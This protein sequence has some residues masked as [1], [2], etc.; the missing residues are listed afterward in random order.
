VILRRLHARAGQII[1]LGTVLILTLTA[2]AQAAKTQYVTTEEMH[3]FVVV[4]FLSGAGVVLGGLAVVFSM[5]TRYRDSEMHAAIEANAATVQSNAEQISE[6]IKMM[7]NH[8]V[9]PFAHPIGS[10]TRIDPIN[11][12]LDALTEKLNTLIG[13]HD[14]IQGQEH[15]ICEALAELR[16][17]NPADS[18]YPKRKDDSRDDYTPLR[19][20]KP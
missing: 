5:V 2:A 13:Q 12:K 11:R 16:H 14:A 7:E 3:R 1:V 18:P 9:D 17:R 15:G 8:H 20:P 4:T 19:G 10:A 6:L